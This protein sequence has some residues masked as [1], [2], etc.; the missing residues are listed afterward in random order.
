[1]LEGI[2]IFGNPCINASQSAQ[3]V[4]DNDY[5]CCPISSSSSVYQLIKDYR[6][7]YQLDIDEDEWQTALVQ[8]A[9]PFAKE[10]VVVIAPGSFQLSRKLLAEAKRKKVDLALLP[11][12]CFPAAKIEEMRKRISARSIDPDGRIFPR[13]TEIALGQSADEYFNLL[14][15]YMQNQLKKTD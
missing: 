13:E 11:L 12:N 9:I 7:L 14:P 2:T 5:R 6:R 4:E 15:P 8:F 3:W 1:M 10:R